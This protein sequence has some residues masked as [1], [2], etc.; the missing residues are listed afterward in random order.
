MAFSP[1]PL[2]DIRHTSLLF[3]CAWMYQQGLLSL[4]NHRSFFLH[5]EYLGTVANPKIW[6]VS[7]EA[8]ASKLELYQ[9]LVPVDEN[10]TGNR[11]TKKTGDLEDGIGS[12][13][14][15]TM[16]EKEIKNRLGE[17]EISIHSQSVTNEIREFVLA[18]G[19][20]GDDVDARQHG[21]KVRGKSA[22]HPSA[23][24]SSLQTHT[25]RVKLHTEYSLLPCPSLIPILEKCCVPA[26]P[27]RIQIQIRGSP[28]EL[29]WIESSVD[30]LAAHEKDRL[31]QPLSRTNLGIWSPVTRACPGNSLITGS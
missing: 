29:R 15:M 16:I 13:I 12:D 17:E 23:L 9:I 11:K 27:Q 31:K 14:S 30:D 28:Q 8:P 7:L 26:R 21:G 25:Q 22:V 24:P 1:G 5:V 2:L 10:V 19:A 3:S 20:P 4:W 18:D 6:N